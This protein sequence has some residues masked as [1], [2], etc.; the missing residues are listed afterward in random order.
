MSTFLVEGPQAE[1][2]SLVA[3]KTHL[4]VDHSDEDDLID[5]LISAARQHVERETGRSLISQVWRVDLA[6]F[7]PWPILLAHGP[8]IEVSGI[9]YFD[10]AGASADLPDDD[11]LFDQTGDVPKVTL[12][13]GAVSPSTSKRPDAVSVTYEAG[14]GTAA[15]VPAD[16]KVA[17]LLLAG[18][19]HANREAAANGDFRTIPM[20]AQS[21]IDSYRIPRLA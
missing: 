7:P 15:D 12:I 10:A 18:H 1:P 2:V 14:Y 9:T 6:S 3:M 17:I 5:L 11:W 16:F 8:V 4:R 21:V 13:P 19:W 20:A